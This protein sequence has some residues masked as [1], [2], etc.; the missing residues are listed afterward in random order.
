MKQKFNITGMT[1]A[2]HGMFHAVGAPIHLT[3]AG[4][5]NPPLRQ[6]FARGAKH[7]S[8]PFGARAVARGRTGHA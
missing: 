5:M 8:A 4:G 2:P 6:G 3:C 7:L 1:C